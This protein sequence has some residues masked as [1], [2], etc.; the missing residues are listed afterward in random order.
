MGRFA[1]DPNRFIKRNTKKT[2]HRLIRLWTSLTTKEG[3]LYMI[4]NKMYQVNNGK[5]TYIGKVCDMYEGDYTS[6]PR[7]EIINE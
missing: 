1:I 2:K 4:D 5:Y 7:T 3:S 6:I